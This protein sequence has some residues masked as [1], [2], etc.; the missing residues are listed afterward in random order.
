MKILAI[1]K[2]KLRVN[3]ENLPLSRYE[4][5]SFR[6][7][8]KGPEPLSPWQNT[9][10]FVRFGHSW[11]GTGRFPDSELRGWFDEFLFFFGLTPFQWRWFVSRCQAPL[12]GPAR[13]LGR[14]AGAGQQGAK[15]WKKN[16][17]HDWLIK[18]KTCHWDIRLNSVRKSCSIVSLGEKNHLWWHTYRYLN[19]TIGS[20]IVSSRVSTKDRVHGSFGS[21]FLFLVGV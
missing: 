7:T 1:L 19:S 21:Q 9:N 14:T 16:W 11:S 2:V 4:P 15:N 13:P 6:K 5:M 17:P 20:A 12:P 8:L 18:K 3:W 10:P